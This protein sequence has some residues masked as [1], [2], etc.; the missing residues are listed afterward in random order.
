M[1]N[2]TCLPSDIIALVV[3]CRLRYRLA[4]RN[5]SEII[6]MRGIEISYEAVR[7]WKA[8]L[9]PVM[10]DELRKRRF[11]ARPCLRPSQRTGPP[12]PPPLRRRCRSSGA[13][14]RTTSSAWG[15]ARS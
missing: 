15:T 7:D 3:F 12:R 2:R 5:L 14:S 1:L 9:L 4:L 13:C 6:G 10:G 11:G 8:K